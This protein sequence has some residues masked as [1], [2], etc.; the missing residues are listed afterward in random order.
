M[1]A[2]PTPFESKEEITRRLDQLESDYRRGELRDIVIAHPLLIVSFA[3]PAILL[4]AFMNL[5]LVPHFGEEIGLLMGLILFVM[6]I[7]VIF[8]LLYNTLTRWSLRSSSKIPIVSAF[9]KAF[10]HDDGESRE[11]ALNI[12]DQEFEE[13]AIAKVILGSPTGLDL[14]TFGE[15]LMTTEEE[16]G[17]EKEFAFQCDPGL[18]KDDTVKALTH[19]GNRLQGL[20]DGTLRPETEAQEHFVKV[21]RTEED[22]FTQPEK[23]WRSYQDAIKWQSYIDAMDDPTLLEYV[24]SYPYV[25]ER[26]QYVHHRLKQTETKSEDGQRQTRYRSACD[27]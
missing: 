22:P 12:L 23:I 2:I 1:R 20:A 3:V 25:D 4:I 21:H 18:L 15:L 24:R 5:V 13:Y 11:V 6:L 9:D 16:S 19:Y 10:P 17:V 7:F 27:G 8:D 26:S 14:E